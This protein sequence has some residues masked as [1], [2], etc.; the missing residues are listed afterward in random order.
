MWA[1]QAAAGRAERKSE[2]EMM[3]LAMARARAQMERG[4]WARL[5]LTRR[6]ALISSLAVDAYWVFLGAGKRDVEA[7]VDL[8]P[9]LHRRAAKGTSSSS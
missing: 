6:A 3:K 8:A 2:K 7:A 5:W 1:E 4:R 9:D